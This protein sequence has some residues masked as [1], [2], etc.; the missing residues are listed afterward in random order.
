MIASKP[1]SQPGTA[2]LEDSGDPVLMPNV[3]VEQAAWSAT[4]LGLITGTRIDTEAQARF[5]DI[6]LPERSHEYLHP[7]TPIEI[8]KLCADALEA[9]R[10]RRGILNAGSYSHRPILANTAEIQ[11]IED[12]AF[13]GLATP[14]GLLKLIRGIYIPS[15]ELAKITFRGSLWPAMRKDVHSAMQA[16]SSDSEWKASTLDKAMKI[17]LSAHDESK[18]GEL[19]GFYVRARKDRGHAGALKVREVVSAIIRIDEASGFDQKAADVLRD[20]HNQQHSL[21]QFIQND[22]T[23]HIIKDLEAHLADDTEEFP[24][25]AIPLTSTVYAFDKDWKAPEITQESA[26]IS[27][28]AWDEHLAQ[29]AEEARRRTIAQEQPKGGGGWILRND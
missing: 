15:V 11:Q 27:R 8:V 20:S 6:D 14:L 24:G 28:E 2:P 10:H 1:D 23:R 4:P 19:S 7:D 18:E 5:Y 3:T 13:A 22:D 25:W 12:A 29:L 17:G 21:E 16:F 9:A 26:C